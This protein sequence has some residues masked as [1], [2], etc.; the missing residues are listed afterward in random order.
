MVPV[1]PKVVPLERAVFPSTEDIT[2]TTAKADHSQSAVRKQP[3]REVKRRHDWKGM[4][5]NV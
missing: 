2:P 1:E 5:S 3:E 4:L